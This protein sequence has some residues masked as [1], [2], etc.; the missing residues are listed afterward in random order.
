MTTK[1]LEK[2]NAAIEEDVVT[3]N[4]DN[5]NGLDTNDGSDGARLKSLVEAEDRIPPVHGPVIINIYPYDAFTPNVGAYI[6]PTFRP[7]ISRDQLL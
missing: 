1:L 5:I 4:V 2:Y 3:L 7:R 6:W